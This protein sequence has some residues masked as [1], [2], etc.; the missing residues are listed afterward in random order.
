M[1]RVGVL[2]GAATA[3]VALGVGLAGCGS[4]PTGSD[5]PTAA[6]TKDM[7]TTT[8]SK[9]QPKVATLPGN[10]GPNPTIAGYIQ[11]NGITRIP[12]H[13]GD[14][15]APTI[16]LP[17]PDSY[18]DAG[19]DTPEGAY[20]AV[21]YTGAKA[22]AYTPSIVGWLSK[23]TGDVDQQRIL[24][25]ASGQLKNLPDFTAFGDGSSSTLGG[26]PAYQ[27]GG[28]WVS[29]GQTKMVAQKTVVIPAGDGVYLLQL[30]VDCLEDQFA[31]VADVTHT[32]DEQ[33][34]VTTH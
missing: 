22:E 15:G 13:R 28:T 31:Q 17:T 33:T 18:A 29:D 21:V 19:P 26:F 8:T 12:V 2:G 7:T 9:P 14:P 23:L 4:H 6:S 3:I 32:I 10:P 24:D 27:L 16:N 20:Y 1:Q 30:N 5:A 11:Q 34:T 25:L